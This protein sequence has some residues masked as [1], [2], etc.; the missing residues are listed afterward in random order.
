MK[1]AADRPPKEFCLGGVDDAP[2]LCLI[3]HWPENTVIRGDEE[4]FRRFDDDGSSR[5]PDAGVDDHDEDRLQG[6][7]WQ[8]DRQDDRRLT[9]ALRSDLVTDVDQLE[10][11]VNAEHDPLHHCDK[12]IALTEIRQQC[13]DP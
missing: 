2:N 12:G 7:K 9:T 4:M 6:K 11:G 8:G 13:D 3:E 1:G 5:S 10:S